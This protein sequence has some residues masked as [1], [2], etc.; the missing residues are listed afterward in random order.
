MART[1]P[2]DLR[3]ALDLAEMTRPDGGLAQQLPLPAQDWR[4]YQVDGLVRDPGKGWCLELTRVGADSSTLVQKFA[5]ASDA[6]VL[7]A[8]TRLEHGTKDD[9]LRFAKD[10]GALDMSGPD[11]S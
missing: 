10:F 4:G 7:E 6:G 3:R 2:P 9:V 1:L 8:F 11:P 5:R